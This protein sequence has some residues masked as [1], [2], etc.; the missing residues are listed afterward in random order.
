MT[1]DDGS[2]LFYALSACVA[3]GIWLV[4]ARYT[5]VKNRAVPFIW[6]APDVSF[7]HAL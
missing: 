1:L 6:P 3:V 5:S 4:F 7:V 2:G